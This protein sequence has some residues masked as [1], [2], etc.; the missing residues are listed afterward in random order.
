MMNTLRRASKYLVQGTRRPLSTAAS[1]TQPQDSQAEATALRRAKSKAWQAEL[2]RS[3]LQPDYFSVLQLFSVQQ[4]FEARCHLGHKE[5]NL[6]PFMRPYVLGSRF[7]QVII[8]LDQT[9]ALL[10]DALNFVSHIAFRD[11]VIL[12]VCQGRQHQ[13]AVEEV[14]AGC[15]EL[16]QTRH[17]RAGTLTDSTV[18]FRGQI[19][20]PDTLIVLSTL[21]QVNE[22]HLCVKDAARMRIPTVAVCDTNSDPRLVTYPVPANDDSTDSVNFLANLFAT[23]IKNAKSKRAEFLANLQLS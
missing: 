20:L 8:D 5:G 4:L 16:A 11:G 21:T 13:L 9:T 22:Q 14:A 2:Q 23:A 10:A 3:L 17:W 1:S 18:M 15:G 12:F 6:N 19:R 7:E